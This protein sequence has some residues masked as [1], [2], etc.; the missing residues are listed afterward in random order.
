MTSL[1]D[2]R[3][4][5]KHAAIEIASLTRS[6]LAYFFSVFFNELPED[7]RKGIV[8]TVAGY[9]FEDAGK[10]LRIDGWMDSCFTKH[11]D[12]SPKKVTDMCCKYYNINAR[13]K[14]TIFKR[15]RKIKDRIR[16]RLSYALLAQID[17][18]AFM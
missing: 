4:R 18:D 1:R 9:Q 5:I 10:W 16:K 8:E 17:K 12:Y 14:P 2:E 11:H 6:D 3:K 7:K 13:M 15:A